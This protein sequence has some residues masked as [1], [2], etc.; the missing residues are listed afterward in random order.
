MQKYFYKQKR[1]QPTDFMLINNSMNASMNNE[2]PDEFALQDSYCFEDNFLFKTNYQAFLNSLSDLEKKVFLLT[3]NGAKQTEIAQR[4]GIAQSAVSITFAKAKRKLV[5]YFD[6]DINEYKNLRTKKLFNN[7]NLSYQKYSMK[8][9]NKLKSEAEN[10][11]LNTLK[12]LYPSYPYKLLY[13][14]KN[15]KDLTLWIKDE[16][17]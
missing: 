6:I 3:L 7:C 2:F 9:I 8:I 15:E 10:L 4:L 11:S 5:K 13:D 1:E 14:I 17:S 12:Q 16:E